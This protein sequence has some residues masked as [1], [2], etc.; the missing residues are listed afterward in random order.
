[1]EGA[2]LI[3][4]TRSDGDNY[5]LYWNTRPSIDMATRVDLG[6]SNRYVDQLGAGSVQ[7]WYAIKPKKARLEG[8]VSVWVTATT[9][10]LGVAITPPTPPPASQNPVT[11]Q[12]T[13]SVEVG[14]PTAGQYQET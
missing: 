12:Q 6:Q 9:L 7:R 1:M 2:N 10:A 13:D 8:D 5:V 4:F 14:Y 11:D 3:E